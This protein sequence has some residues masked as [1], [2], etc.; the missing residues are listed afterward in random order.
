MEQFNLNTI[1]GK[2]APVCHASQYDTGRVIRVNL[3]EGDQVYTLDGTEVVSVSVRKPDGHIVTEGVTN[4]SAAYVE[5]VTTE[6]MTACY[7]ANLCELKIEKGAD[8]LG[9]LN[10]I[11]SVEEDPLAGGDPSESFVYN[12]ATQIYNAVADQYDSNNVIFDAAPTPGH[13]V[14]YTV[15]SEGID[16]AIPQDLDDLNDVTTT[17]PASGEALVWDGTKWVNGTPTLDVEDLDNVT[18]TTPSNGDIMVYNNG[19][20]ENQANPSSTSNFAPDY[21]DTAT[22]NTNDKVIYQGLLYVCLEDSVTG[23][24]DGTKWQQISVA[25]LNAELLPIQ[26]GSATNTKDYIDTGLSGKQATL[27]YESDDYNVTTYG[28]VIR[29]K[30]WGR[31][32]NIQGYSIGS[33]QALPIASAVTLST[34]ASKYR[35]DPQQHFFGTGNAGSYKYDTAQAYRVNTDGTIMTYVYSGTSVTNGYFN[36]TYMV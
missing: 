29:C 18:I 5:I 32:V 23:A 4:T 19:T 36:V 28:G 20:W 7:G 26:S 33:V 6:Q 31:V 9:T 17:T 25:D 21:D 3:Y 16:A 10:F 13:G 11:L 2:V 14:P 1:P 27:T 8:V 35:P 24:W 15:T 22:Y 30:K 12:L 34:I